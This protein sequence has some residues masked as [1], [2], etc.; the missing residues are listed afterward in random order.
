MQCTACTLEF[1]PNNIEIFD[2]YK[3]V[4]ELSKISKFRTVHILI[5][6]EI[7]SVFDPLIYVYKVSVHAHL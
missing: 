5:P 2:V 1:E 3:I 6:L 4:M 7:A